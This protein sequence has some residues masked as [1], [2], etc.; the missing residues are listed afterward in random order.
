MHPHYHTRFLVLVLSVLILGGCATLA[1]GPVFSEAKAAPPESGKALVYV[2]RER[3]EPVAWGT[4]I[5]FDRSVVANLRNK[6]FTWAYLD[7]GEY[8]IRAAWPLL[9]AQSSA[10]F[11][12]TARAGETYYLELQGIS[13][14][15]GTWVTVGSGLIPRD[16]RVAE[17][18]I[19]SCCRF[20]PPA[21]SHYS[22]QP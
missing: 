1:N 7:P 12:L 16:P 2:F 11:R 18:R 13:E 17:W 8:R 21:E 3:A 14:I 6:G 5:Y 22:P 20:E 19:S 15:S 4:T 9:A 10:T